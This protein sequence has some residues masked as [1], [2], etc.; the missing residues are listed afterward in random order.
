MAN[1]ID[2]KKYNDPCVRSMAWVLSCPSIIQANDGLPLPSDDT[3]ANEIAEIINKS[4]THSW[5]KPKK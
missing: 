5:G 1:R 3:Q 4:N 2:W